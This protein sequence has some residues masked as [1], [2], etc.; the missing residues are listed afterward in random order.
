MINILEQPGVVGDGVHDDCAGIQKVIGS[1]GEGE[2]LYFPLGEYRTVGLLYVNQKRRMTLCGPGHLRPDGLELMKVSGSGRDGGSICL[3]GLSISGSVYLNK[4]HN[5]RIDQCHFMGPATWP[6]VQIFGTHDVT[7]ERCTFD[8]RTVGIENQ[9]PD[10]AIYGNLFRGCDVAIRNTSAAVMID[11][12]RMFPYPDV[13]QTGILLDGMAKWMNLIQITNNHIGHPTGF[14]IDSPEHYLNRN[15][16]L[17]QGNQFMQEEG[18]DLVRNVEM[19][20]HDQQIARV[21][22]PN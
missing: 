19:V 4:S 5:V 20:V 7:V 18:K 11:H 1:A 8:D 12:N 9:A 6:G 17:I 3:T 16:C 22:M 13:M 10:T 2:S 21:S 14:C 15:I